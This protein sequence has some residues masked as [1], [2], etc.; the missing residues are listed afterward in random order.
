[1]RPYGYLA[2]PYRALLLVSIDQGS[3]KFLLKTDISVLLD[4]KRG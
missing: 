3:S 2:L 1:M 4:F